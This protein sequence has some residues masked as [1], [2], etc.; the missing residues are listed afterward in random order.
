M[1]LCQLRFR[2]ELTFGAVHCRTAASNYVKICQPHKVTSGALAKKF[3]I[4]FETMTKFSL[5]VS[6]RRGYINKIKVVAH[7]NDFQSD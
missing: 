2:D 7:E 3:H 4:P 1:Q 5:S 6:Q